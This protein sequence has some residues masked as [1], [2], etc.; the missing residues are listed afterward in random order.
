MSDFEQVHFHVNL[1]LVVLNGTQRVT[2]GPSREAGVSTPLKGSF[3]FG[4]YTKQ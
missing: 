1:S 3:H 2:G 4:K